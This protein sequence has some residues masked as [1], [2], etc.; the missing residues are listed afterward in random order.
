MTSATDRIEA[1]Y[2]RFAG[3]Y[4]TIATALPTRWRARAVD[5]LVLSP[6]DTVVEVGCG[7]GANLRLLR[8][9]VGPTGRVVGV[10]LTPSMLKQADRRIERAGWENVSCIRGDASRPPVTEAT[11]VLGTFVVG[12]LSD[13]V[14][15][16]E[17]WCTLATD[18]VALLDGA[19]SSHPIG[20]LC[21]PLFGAFVGAGMP[22]DSVRET[23]GQL[24]AP[25]A[26]RHSLDAAVSSS[27]TALAEHTTRHHA[28]T[29][30]GGFLTLSAGCPA[31]TP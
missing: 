4:D 13:P 20:R 10:D 18:R 15:A 30:G 9:R 25:T 7:T 27:Q 6:G 22:A 21:N 19:S 29:F 2:G 23:L 1:F 12:L 14:A 11:A 5:A 17:T 3:V 24:T 16:V 8:E 26:A 28:E 31:T